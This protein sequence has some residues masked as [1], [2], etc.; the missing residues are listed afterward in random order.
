MC[1]VLCFSTGETVTV[2]ALV[3]VDV[4]VTGWILVSHIR[5]R[6]EGR[7]RVL[8]QGGDSTAQ[9]STVQYDTVNCGAV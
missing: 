4:T 6:M 2:S 1:D 9:F 3:A 7:K 8:E 5:V